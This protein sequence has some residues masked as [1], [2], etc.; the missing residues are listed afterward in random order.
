KHNDN[1]NQIQSRELLRQ[2]PPPILVTN[3]TMLEY[4]LI[5]QLDKSI[6]DKSKG[7]L[8]WIVLDEAH[9]YLGSTASEL[10]LLLKR[11][12]LA[13]E[14]EPKNVHFIA[15][16]ATIGDDEK[17]KQQLKSF[18]A[19]LSGTHEQQIHIITAQRAVPPI[20]LSNDSINETT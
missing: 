11:V 9:S 16:S 12:M 6:I 13:F 20:T 18:L 5:R 1:K 7:K 19:S 17:A 15:T 8:K 2:T 3:A 14:V 4:M 10:S